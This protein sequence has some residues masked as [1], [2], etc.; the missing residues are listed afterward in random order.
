MKVSEERLSIKKDKHN[1]ISQFSNRPQRK[2][3]TICQILP[4]FVKTTTTKINKHSIVNL[5]KVIEEWLTSKKEK[6]YT[7]TQFSKRPQTKLKIL[8][9]ILPQFVIKTFQKTIQH[10]F[11]KDLYRTRTKH[12]FQ[13]IQLKSKKGSKYLL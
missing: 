1:T 10:N 11:R 13:K 12:I 9:Q 5:T 4:Q 6:R 7:I 3:K 2:F 8:W